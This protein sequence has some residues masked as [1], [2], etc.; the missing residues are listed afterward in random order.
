M[1]GKRISKSEFLRRLAALLGSGDLLSWPRRKAD[2]HILLKSV[3]LL[4]AP[5]REYSEPEF[6]TLIEEWLDLTS[7]SV[8]IDVA[9]IRRALVDEGYVTRDI[10]GSTYQA[11]GLG[12]GHFEFETAIGQIDLRR[13]LRTG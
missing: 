3:M 13:T 12:P 9:N 10:A 1:T 4:V 11:A 2:R 5:A 7:P 6:N 8:R